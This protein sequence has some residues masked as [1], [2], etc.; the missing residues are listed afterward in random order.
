[1]VSI[2][3]ESASFF[4]EDSV[5]VERFLAGDQDAFTI[6]YTKYYQRVFSIAKGILILE[7]EALDVTQEVFT[8]VYRN[9][10]KFNRQSKF[11]TWLFRIA[12]NRSIQESRKRRFKHKQVELTEEIEHVQPAHED[13]VDPRVQACMEQLSPPDRALLT[14][15]YWQDQSLTEI[16]QSMDINVNAAKTRLYRA[17]E[18][19][20]ELY[21]KEPQP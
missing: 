4:D 18:R 11:S 6:L 12:V 9:L 19:F 1:M 13:D 16:A 8:L 5:N 14:L 3:L 10:G 17:R 7:D 21:E 15:F 2:Y 20:R